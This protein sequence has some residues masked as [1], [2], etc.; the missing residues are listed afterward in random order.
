MLIQE[1]FLNKTN[2][3]I[4]KKLSDSCPSDFLSAAE[5]KFKEVGHYI[6]VEGEAKRIRPLVCFAYQSLFTSNI[7]ERVVKI[8]ASCELIHCASLLHDDVV[9]NADKRR[10]KKSA[11]I[12]YGN[13]I[14]ILT[15]NYLLTLAFELLESLEP[16]IINRAILV[17]KDMSIACMMEIDARGKL[18]VNNNYWQEIALKKT[19]ALFAWCGFSI[20]FLLGNKEDINRLIKLSNHVGLIF[21]MLDDIKDFNKDNNNKVYCND[22][23]NHDLSLP[24][25]IAAQKNLD[26][27]TILKQA[28]LKENLLLEEIEFLKKIIINSGSIVEIKNIINKEI[29]CINNIVDYYEK[30]LGKNYIKNIIKNLN[31]TNLK[32]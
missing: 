1:E 30:S 12:V 2:Q 22:L 3:L 9:D 5:K 7:D 28:F 18:D 16:E 10:G 27:Y 31:Y 25:I 29:L 4:A 24:I 26:N 14:S 20:A 32:L 11:N 8:A 6:S 17:L 23:K 21:Q 13:S 19:A 15:G